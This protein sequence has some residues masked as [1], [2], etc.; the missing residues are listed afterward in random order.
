VTNRIAARLAKLEK[1][2][3]T[4]SPADG[5]S[6][7]AELF[8]F[9]DHVI[10]L[11]VRMEAEGKLDAKIVEKFRHGKNT[12]EYIAA[13]PSGYNPNW[14]EQYAALIL[15]KWLDLFEKIR[16]DREAA[17]DVENT[18]GNGSKEPRTERTEDDNQS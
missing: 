16:H 5:G 13:H 12:L 18:M 8:V 10:G 4:P 15:K 1:T 3:P 2:M 11:A 6:A 7:V 14:P 9:Y 17:A